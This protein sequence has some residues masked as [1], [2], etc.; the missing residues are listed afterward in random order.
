MPKSEEREGIAN[1]CSIGFSTSVLKK[2]TGVSG[3]KPSQFVEEES[4]LEKCVQ[5]QKR[6]VIFFFFLLKKALVMEAQHSFLEIIL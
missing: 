1:L 6:G 2:F 5:L 4:D 3:C